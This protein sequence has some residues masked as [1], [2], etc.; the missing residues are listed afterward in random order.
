MIN[1][2]LSIN[3]K[4]IKDEYI[5]NNFILRYNINSIIEEQDE[6]LSIIYNDGWENIFLGFD[7][8]HNDW[9]RMSFVNIHQDNIDAVIREIKLNKI[10][11]EN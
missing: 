4:Q 10:L 8:N 1:I 2:L 11:N 6:D 3:K 5:I 7:F 9:T